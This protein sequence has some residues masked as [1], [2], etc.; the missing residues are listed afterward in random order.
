MSD[1]PIAEGRYSSVSE[2]I[3]ELIQ[4]DEKHNAE[5]RLTTLLPEGLDSD[6]SELT[7]GDF[8]EIRK[9]ALAELK[10]R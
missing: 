8:A 2:Y 10:R 1:H 5:E 9:E 6:E 7:S 3:Q 4:S